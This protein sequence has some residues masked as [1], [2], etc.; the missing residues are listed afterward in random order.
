LKTDEVYFKSDSPILDPT[1]LERLWEMSYLQKKT[2]AMVRE[3]FFLKYVNIVE[4]EINGSD[5]ICTSYMFP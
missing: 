1:L 4:S 3:V 2:Q 5:L